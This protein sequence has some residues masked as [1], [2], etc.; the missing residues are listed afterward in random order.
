M[1]DSLRQYNYYDILNRI[2][3]DFLI[4]E[5][6][7]LIIKDNFTNNVFY[8]FFCVIFRFSHI[9]LFSCDYSSIFKNSNNSQI[10]LK[11]LKK[12]TLYN[13]IEFF[14]I[15]YKTYI[16]INF[17]LYFFFLIR[18]IIYILLVRDISLYKFPKKWP[19][20]NKFRIITDHIIFLFFPYILEFIVFPYYMVIFPDKS[21]IKLSISLESTCIISRIGFK[22]WFN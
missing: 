15:S 3:K 8:Y 7:F 19:L 6:L 11:I 12:L 9:L 5:P 14:Q 16:I 1:S 20:Q 4:G 13:T 21:I 10:I 2:K 22:S 17:L 18:L